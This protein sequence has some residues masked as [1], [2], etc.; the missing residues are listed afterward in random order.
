MLFGE[1]IA[2]YSEIQTDILYAKH[3]VS[4]CVAGAALVTT[5]FQRAK[6]RGISFAQGLNLHVGKLDEIFYLSPPKMEF[7]E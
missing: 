5:L 4:E 7:G 6:L 1:V 2:A 3:T